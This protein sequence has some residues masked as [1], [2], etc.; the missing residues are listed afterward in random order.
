MIAKYG[1]SK[2]LF[3]TSAFINEILILND[4]N[5]YC[6]RSS[7]SK[8]RSKNFNQVKMYIYSF[9]IKKCHSQTLLFFGR[10]IIKRVKKNFFLTLTFTPRCGLLTFWPNSIFFKGNNLIYWYNHQKND[11]C[12]ELLCSKAL[13]AWILNS[14]EMTMKLF[15]YITYN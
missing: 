1:I 2:S 6:G 12:Y 9:Q 4:L 5:A 8:L 15:H 7:A 11:F 14:T 13:Q 3:T 10:F